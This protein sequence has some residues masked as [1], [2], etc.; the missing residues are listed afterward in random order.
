[1]AEIVA[2]AADAR[3]CVANDSG[4]AHIAAAL[5]VPTVV[6]FGSSNVVHWRPWSAAPSAVVRQE[7][8]CGPCPGYTCAASPPLACIKRI[9]VEQVLGAIERVLMDA[10]AASGVVG[11]STR[12]MG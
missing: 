4:V 6:I 10:G 8:E 2:L 5:R 11:A 1:L 9:S 12:G 3:L 7:V